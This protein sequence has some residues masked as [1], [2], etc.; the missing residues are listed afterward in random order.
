MRAASIHGYLEITSIIGAT[1]QRI[2][3]IL[4][5]MLVMEPVTKIVIYFQNEKD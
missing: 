5:I 4:S 2:H 3:S 1:I